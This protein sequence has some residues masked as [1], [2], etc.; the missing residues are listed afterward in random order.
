LRRKD[1]VSGWVPYLFVSFIVAC[2]ITHLFGIWTL[3]VPDY[4]LQAA[5][6][7]GTAAVS[8]TTAVALW[9]L[10]PKLL[11]LP[12]PKLLAEKNALLAREVHDRREAERRLSEL[13]A[14]LERRV[15]DRT[16]SL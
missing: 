11:A 1:L 12:S 5:I 6:K 4:G 14:Q 3:W 2:G 13:N 16:A 15:A 7:V 10:M 9:P 8:L